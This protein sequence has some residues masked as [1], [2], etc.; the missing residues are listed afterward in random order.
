MNEE[1][2]TSLQEQIAET[3][4]AEQIE[5]SKNPALRWYL[6]LIFFMPT[7]VC[8]TLALLTSIVQRLPWVARFQIDGDWLALSYV[9]VI[10]VSTFILGLIH[11]RLYDAVHPE[12]IPKRGV[13]LFWHAV[14]FFFLQ[15]LVVPVTVFAIAFLMSIFL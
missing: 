12:N 10:C 9:I 8:V 14:K 1:N 6:R 2:Q 4:I 3:A 15:I 5:R 11:S 7:M 13:A